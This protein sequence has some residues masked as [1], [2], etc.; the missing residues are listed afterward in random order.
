MAGK[1][2][3]REL[4]TVWGFDI[5]E[6][7]INDIEDSV[8]SI[9][10]TIKQM[11]IAVGAAAAG[12]GFLLREA[13]E[14]E[15]TKIAFETMLG[16]ADLALK[17]INEL[18]E[19]A[20]KTPFELRGIKVAARR[21]LAFNFSA[22][23]LMPTLKALGDLTAG[24]GVERMPQLILALGQVKAA[25]KL[26]G[27]ELR[28]F[29]EAGVPLISELAKVL[30]KPEKEIQNLV[31]AGKVGFE[32]VRKALF[33][34][35]EEGGRFNN[36]MA[37]QSKSLFGLW[38]NVKDIINIISIEI[39]NKILPEAKAVLKEFLKW[40]DVNRELLKE[41]IG[42]FFKGLIKFIKNTIKVL[43]PFALAIH[44]VVKAFG[45]WNKVLEK[46]MELFLAFGAF[47]LLI[48]IGKI[49][50]GIW[51]VVSAFKAMGAA[52][53][54]AQAK[55]LAIP[56]AI[57]A[58]IV[59]IGLIIED[60]VTFF[61]G[62]KSV[63]GL[64]LDA[65]SKFSDEIINI[66]AVMFGPIAQIIFSVK[67]LIISEFEDIVNF[68]ENSADKIKQSFSS[69]FNWFQ[70]KIEETG[71]G[72]ILSILGKTISP[73]LGLISPAIQAAQGVIGGSDQV[74]VFQN[75]I[76][77][78]NQVESFQNAPITGM[79][80][81]PFKSEKDQNKVV[82]VKA[83]NKLELNV[84]GMNPDDAKEVLST[85][86]L[87]EMGVMLRETVRDGESQIER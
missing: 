39:G 73:T 17:K 74:E 27:Q 57:G 48:A 42:E 77:A 29:T 60:I 86:V 6:K 1:S 12:V 35:T 56:L 70:N 75:T 45:G 15:Q 21:L 67:D 38:S 81:T 3:V 4:V 55:L 43:K 62:G 2:I 71:M 14:D 51:L 68:A 64:L 28:Q 61:Q 47:K 16:S 72:K 24:L 58:I 33:Q 8:R 83:N 36:L 79:G 87:D 34:L 5:D 7:P 20:A 50:T 59:A 84:T 63:F 25:T 66:F 52:A 76:D 11:T 37:K 78:N 19:F 85:T 18:K 69:L 65:L 13:G 49:T 30:G 10:S 32:D 26:R 80:S 31:S 82:N 22:E 46:T 54:L 53:I 23:E 44:G 9:K 40:L 41:N